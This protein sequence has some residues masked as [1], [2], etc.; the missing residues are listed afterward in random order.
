MGHDPRV[1]AGQYAPGAMR[2]PFALV[3][4]LL[5][6][7]PACGA[8]PSSSEDFKGEERAVAEVVEALQS[9]GERRDATKICNEILAADLKARLEEGDGSCLEE[10][11]DALDEAEDTDLVV[12]NVQITGTTATAKVLGRDGK[13]DRLAS[14]SLRKESG[15][16]RLTALTP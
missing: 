6:V 15:R 8:Q 14:M 10:I 1:E 13:A 4:G 16:W 5:L 11:K 3:L 12:K 9:A 2:R 7:L